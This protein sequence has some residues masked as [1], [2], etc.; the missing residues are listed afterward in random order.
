MR[1]R[2]RHVSAFEGYQRWAATYDSTP[3][4]IVALDSQSTPAFLAPQ[5][6]EL[7][8]DAGCGTG[9]SLP[10]MLQAGATPVG[11]DF[12]VEMLK[13]ARRRHP[14]VN[15]VAADLQRPFPLRSGRFDA[16][17][18][19]LVGEHLEELRSFF[20]EVRRVLRPRGRL[21]FS[22]YHPELAAAGVEANFQDAG[23][24]YR[25]GAARHTAADY[26]MV[27]SDTGFVKLTS[28]EFAGNEALAR[29]IPG[30]DR[31][32]GRPVLLVLTAEAPM[33]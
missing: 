27:M 15:L 18:C 1:R 28:D 25:L 20:R 8:L 6:G 21:V 33:H 14:R 30:A 31:Y 32:L 2:V 16:A 22:V 23:V 17:L 13:A 5:S 24:E 26:L 19:S 10:A 9:R 7:I 11:V 3:N 4:P 12:S 29:S